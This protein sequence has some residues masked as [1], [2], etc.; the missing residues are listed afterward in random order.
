MH[1]QLA[2]LQFVVTM[3]GFPA[4]RQVAQRLLGGPDPTRRGLDQPVLMVNKTKAASPT[5]LSMSSLP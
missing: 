1:P 2:D 3:P 4:L 5:E